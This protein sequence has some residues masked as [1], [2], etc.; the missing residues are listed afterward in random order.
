M[1]FVVVGVVSG[2]HR[3]DIEGCVLGGVGLWFGYFAS[4]GEIE[5]WVMGFVRDVFTFQGEG[6]GGIR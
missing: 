6:D 2:Y 5:S 1:D 3:W 4:R